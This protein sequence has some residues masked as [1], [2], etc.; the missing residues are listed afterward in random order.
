MRGTRATI[1]VAIAAGCT[2]AAGATAAAGT[3]AENAGVSLQTAGQRA[4]AVSYW[5]PARM[6]RAAPLD[7]V[8]PSSG[9]AVAGAART[10]ATASFVPPAGAG[11]SPAPAVL[12]PGGPV[13]VA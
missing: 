1:A 12:L 3:P 9:V 7:L 2:V 8:E 5:T 6:R 10:G 13:A 4:A 11:A